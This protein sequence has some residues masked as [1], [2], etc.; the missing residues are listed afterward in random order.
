MLLNANKN[1]FRKELRDSILFRRKR[2]L[3]TSPGRLLKLGFKKAKNNNLNLLRGNKIMFV[4]LSVYCRKCFLIYFAELKK[5]II[6]EY[7]GK[8]V[9]QMTKVLVAFVI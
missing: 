8:S 3:G 7:N 4:R 6:L 2:A 5:L 9:S 1:I